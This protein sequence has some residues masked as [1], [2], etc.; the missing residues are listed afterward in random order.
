MDEVSS[1]LQRNILLSLLIILLIAG[2]AAA[3]ADR[4][5]SPM[6]LAEILASRETCEQCHEKVTAR[7]VTEHTQGAHG[8][9]GVGCADCHGNDH[10]NMPLATAKKACAQCHAEETAQYLASDH[11]K[12]W[13]NMQA[14]ARYMKQPAVVRTQG[15]EACHRIGAGADDGRCDFCHVKHRFSKEE[16]RRPESCYTCHMGPDH[17]QMEAYI[18]SKHH[19]TTATCTSCHFPATHNVN[20]NLDRPAG[21]AMEK[22]CTDCHELDFTKQWLDGA[23]MLEEQGE[24]LLQ[25]GRAIITRLDSKGL[26]VPAPA[27]REANPVEGKT[28]VLGG[29]QLY[30]DTSRAEKIYFEMHKYLQIHLTQGAYHQDFKMAAYKGLIPLRTALVELESEALLLEELAIGK[31]ILTPISSSLPI[32]EAGDIRQLTY[33]SSFHGVLADGANKPNCA[34]CHGTAEAGPL[35]TRETTAACRK[36]HTAKQTDAFLDDLVAIK[37]HAASLRRDGAQPVD[38]LLAGGVLGKG[39][40]GRLELRFTPASNVNHF[41]ARTIAERLRFYLDDLDVS[42]ENMIA[43]AAHVNPDYAHWYGNAPA[44]SALIEIRDAAHKLEQLHAL[45]GK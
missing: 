36:C 22:L 38:A 2:P 1:R 29:H 21:N 32:R 45:Y 19:Q 18:K 40:D 16:A 13:E 31:D 33:A 30:E 39:K 6:P 41:V 11:S 28:L 3:R 17:P 44:K 5:A 9:A 34:T 37:N 27:E 15:C 23:T 43:G 24:M 14:S 7:V 12:S 20:A 8:L 4:S 35:T 42:L 25:Q 10:R 26:L